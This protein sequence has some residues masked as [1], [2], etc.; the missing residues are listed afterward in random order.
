MTHPNNA[1]EAKAFTAPGSLSSGIPAGH[2]TPPSDGASQP[3]KNGAPNGQQ[4]NGAVQ[5]AT[6]AATPAGQASTGVSGIVPTLQNIVAT[7]N[8]D[9]RV[10]RAMRSEQAHLKIVGSCD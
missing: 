5:P 6:P 8:L 1:Q 7:V 9:C 4:P 2:L 3:Q 10:S